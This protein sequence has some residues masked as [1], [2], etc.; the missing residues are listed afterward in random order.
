M[1]LHLTTVLVP[2]I[3]HGMFKAIR[4]ADM[5]LLVLLILFGAVLTV[6]VFL[7]HDSGDT[8]RITVNGKESGT[9]SLS[10]GREVLSAF[11]TE[12]QSR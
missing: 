12:Y 2:Y 10:E 9:Y 3:M 1:H 5:V 4:K 6:P 11:L 7:W 8:V